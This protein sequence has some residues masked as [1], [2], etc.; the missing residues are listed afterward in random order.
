M[1][2]SNK[3][4]KHLIYHQYVKQLLECGLKNST[5]T[6]KI[7]ML[8]GFAIASN[9]SNYAFLSQQFGL[10]CCCV[11]VVLDTLPSNYNLHASFYATW[12]HPQR[13]FTPRATHNNIIWM[14]HVKKKIPYCSTWWLAH[15]HHITFLKKSRW[16]GHQI[17]FTNLV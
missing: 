16:N 11:H 10:L 5:P 3:F 4:K 12:W 7:S 13:L 15:I 17:I 8:G 6:R 9:L 1:R 2:G 14:Q